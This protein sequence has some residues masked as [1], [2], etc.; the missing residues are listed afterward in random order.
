MYIEPNTDIWLLNDV[1]IDSTYNDTIYW[2]SRIDQFNY[3]TSKIKYHFPK[4]TY[5][6]VQKGV[7]RVGIKADLIYDVDYLMFRNTNYGD[8]VFYA[9]VNSVEYINNEVSEIEFEIDVMQTW[10]LDYTVINSFVEREHSEHDY[11]GYN[12]VPENVELGEV[13]YGNP[14]GLSDTGISIIVAT[15]EHSTFSSVAS[16]VYDGVYGGLFLKVFPSSVDGAREI[17]SYLDHFLSRSEAVVA[18]YTLPSWVLDGVTYDSEG[19]IISGNRGA[20]VIK[21]I[22]G[23]TGTESFGNYTPKNKKLYTYPYNYLTVNNGGNNSLCLRYEYFKDNPTFNIEGTFIQPVQVV[24]Y[25]RNYK[26]QVA[27]TEVATLSGMENLSLDNFPLCSWSYNYFLDWLGRNTVPMLISGVST[28]LTNNVSNSLS[29]G[30]AMTS[31]SPYMAKYRA[32]ITNEAN[33]TTSAINGI[34]SALSQGYTA[35]ITANPCK[36]NIS[37]GNILVAHNRQRFWWFRTHIHEQYAVMIDDYFTKYGYACKRVKK[38]GFTNR[39]HWNYIK[40]IGC[41][42][43]GSIPNDDKKKICNIMDKGIT[44]WRNGTEVGN[45]GLD[46]SPVEPHND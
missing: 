31:T 12:I 19:Y 20:T 39:P 29:T 41:E 16:G 24:L 23:V 40:T 34:S 3:F 30:M 21:T 38:P 17:K 14:H 10:A 7:M 2:T 26:G 44:F 18:I 13:M 46:N 11:V 25:P 35:S 6:R 15:T 9:F 37:N 4:N 22:A 36:G 32:T 42:I 28:A 5:Q 45:Y 43:W 27:G 33:T 1:R 8:K